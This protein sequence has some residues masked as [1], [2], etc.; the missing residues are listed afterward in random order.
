MSSKQDFRLSHHRRLCNFQHV[1]QI[2]LQILQLYPQTSHTSVA[3]YYIIFFLLLLPMALRPAVGFGLSNN[4][5]PFFPICHQLC[6]SSL[7]LYSFFL[8][9][10]FVTI[11]F[12]C[13]GLL[14]P[15]QTPNMEDQGIPF[16]L[17]HHL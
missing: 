13:V 16:C 7:N 5:L 1:T 4:I 8:C 14:A 3:L 17:G 10:T 15:R 6:P 12:Y 9:S 11:I 2:V